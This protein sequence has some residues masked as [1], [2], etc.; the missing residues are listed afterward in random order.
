[1][2]YNRILLLGLIGVA[3]G[4]SKDPSVVASPP[5]TSAKSAPATTAPVTDPAATTEPKVAVGGGCT[6]EKHPGTCTIAETSKVTFEGTLDGKAIKLEGNELDPNAQGFAKIEKGAKT[7]CTLDF[8]TAGTCTPCMI[9]VAQCGP[10][11]WELF[12]SRRR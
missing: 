5:A 2:N 1:M 4:C 10:A 12:R 6:Y 8:E 7:S 11:A 9:S 3:L